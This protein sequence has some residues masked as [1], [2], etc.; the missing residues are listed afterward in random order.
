LKINTF[1]ILLA[2]VC[3]FSAP[4]VA[5]TI[6]FPTQ[7]D[8]QDVAFI[9]WIETAEKQETGMWATGQRELDKLLK[10]QFKLRTAFLTSLCE[11]GEFMFGTELEKYVQAV[12][13]EIL[14]ANPSLAGDYKVFVSRNP[15]PNAYNTGAKIIVV[16]AGLLPRLNS[17]DELAFVLC[18]ELSHQ[19][20]LHV[21][22]GILEYAKRVTNP[23][24]KKR[25]RE[26][27][28]STYK[29]NEQLDAI[30]APGLYKHQ[31]YRRNHEFQA[32]SLGLVFYNNMNL[33]V[34]APALVMLV[35]DEIDHEM[36]TTLFDFKTLFAHDSV[37]WDPLWN[38]FKTTSLPGVGLDEEALENREAEEE[39]LKTHP[40]AL[41][42]F[43]RLIVGISDEALDENKIDLGFDA[44]RQRAMVEQVHACYMQN[45]WSRA[46]YLAL[47]GD[48]M[49]PN[50]PYFK[51]MTVLLLARISLLKTERMTGKFVVLQNLD[52]DESYNRTIAF[53]WE[54]SAKGAASISY[55]L[56]RQ[57][58]TPQPTPTYFEAM[59]FAAKAY[60][61]PT[62]YGKYRPAY[63]NLGALAVHLKEF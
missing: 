52:Y 19:V 15:S 48:K 3:F 41:E 5:Q 21:N 58:L 2:L 14:A 26:A 28:S 47:Q 39:L 6:Y 61:K 50:Q 22:N 23:T 35:L 25:I 31:Q 9:Q 57:W 53:L 13:A 32:D 8:S 29:V 55:H 1:W 42:R 10:D 11:S 60:R 45:N 17:R 16:Q 63:K 34:A 49:F 43:D 4:L 27:L 7:R 44:I 12:F 18:H 59:L 33:S 46:F 37:R 40:D 30:I 20:L 36:D 38:K 54:V 62:D 24:Y 51:Q 56:G